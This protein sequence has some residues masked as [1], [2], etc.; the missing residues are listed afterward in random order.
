MKQKIRNL[1]VVLAVVLASCFPMR[2]ARATGM[3]VIDISAIAAAIVNTFEVLASAAEHTEKFRNIIAAGE[4]TWAAV[5]M[6]RDIT[7]VIHEGTRT[8]LELAEIY[9]YYA[10]IVNRTVEGIQNVSNMRRYTNDY[11]YIMFMI[12]TYSNTLVAAGQI[13]TQTMRYLD[14]AK[15]MMTPEGR[16]NGFRKNLEEMRVL[17]DLMESINQMFYGHILGEALARRLAR[18]S[19]ENG[20][21]VSIA[22]REAIYAANNDP[23]FSGY[24]TFLS[25]VEKSMREQ[26]G[27]EPDWEVNAQPIPIGP[28][29]EIFFA[30]SAIVLLFG[31]YKVFERIQLGED[32]YKSIAVWFLAALF[33]LIV[34]IIAGTFADKRGIA[35]SSGQVLNI[36]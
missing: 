5:E 10:R 19:I 1:A 11:Q 24:Q 36:K 26:Q 6:V 32:I 17:E 2:T 18:R 28:Y 22:V 13:F 27:I 23:F 4:K 30:I 34:G 9:N 25:R 14:P 29:R 35:A 21:P 16:E 15:T 7:N 33:S 31:A 8:A 3:P 12:E 20:T